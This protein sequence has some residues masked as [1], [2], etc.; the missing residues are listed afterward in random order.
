MVL[1][2]VLNGCNGIPGNSPGIV[3]YLI[4]ANWNA[5]MKHLTIEGIPDPLLQGKLLEVC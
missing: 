1:H 2:S 3:A 4:S 5:S